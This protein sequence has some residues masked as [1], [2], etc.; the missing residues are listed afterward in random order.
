MEI[1][2]ENFDLHKGENSEF[3]Q[4]ENF[5]GNQKVLLEVM[6]LV[7]KIAGEFA[8]Y[9]PEILETEIVDKVYQNLKLSMEVDQGDSQMN[10]DITEVYIWTLFRFLSPLEIKTIHENDKESIVQMLS[11]KLDHI[12]ALMSSSNSET[13]LY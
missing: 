7:G 9:V 6:V 5:M 3:E 13:R 11:A 10:N 1:T 8:A 4:K 12:H 2:R